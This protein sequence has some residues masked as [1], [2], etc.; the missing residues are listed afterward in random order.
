MEGAAGAREGG[1][2]RALG[3]S[4]AGSA[5]GGGAA[6]GPLVPPRPRF[7]RSL[8]ASDDILKAP[9]LL[10]LRQ[11]RWHGKQRKLKRWRRRGRGRSCSR[12]TCQ[13]WAFFTYNIFCKKTNKQTNKQIFLKKKKNKKQKTKKKVLLCKMQGAQII[14]IKKYCVHATGPELAHP[15][16]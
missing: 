14:I 16:A 8:S 3:G 10:S 6:A 9:A 2:G 4:P 11:E 15:D 12:R 5:D 1:A 7:A 13:M